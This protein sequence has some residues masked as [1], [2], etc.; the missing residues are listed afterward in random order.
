MPL[1]RPPRFDTF[2]NEIPPGKGSGLR[3]IAAKRESSDLVHPYHRF[4]RAR[5]ASPDHPRPLRGA[6]LESAIVAAGVPNVTRRKSVALELSNPTPREA[7]EYEVPRQK[8]RPT[9][10]ISTRTELKAY[11]RRRA[12]EEYWASTDVPMSVAFPPSSAINRDRPPDPGM[13]YVESVKATAAAAVAAARERKE[14]KRRPATATGCRERFPQRRRP[15]DAD[16]H[17]AKVRATLPR[18]LEAIMRSKARLPVAATHV[19]HASLH[20]WMKQASAETR[21]VLRRFTDV[22]IDYKNEGND[23]QMARRASKDV[24][25]ADRAPLYS[26]F[27]PDSVFRDFRTTQEMIRAQK[28]EDARR[29]RQAV[30][31]DE[32][33]YAVDPSRCKRK[34]N[35]RKK[36]KKKGKAK[37]ALQNK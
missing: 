11:R 19:P 30:V 37:M 9:S 13:A 12:A 20:A 10:A 21:Q 29:A 35:R 23:P 26:S 1:H 2:G 4:F 31:R 24:P 34:T 18:H 36:K 7:Y 33:L 15:R 27:Q 6:N 16:V 32:G 17:P 3:F 25:L 14:G 8:R 28:R 22:V 5:Y